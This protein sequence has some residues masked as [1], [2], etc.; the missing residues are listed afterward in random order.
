[1]E[2]NNGC[3]VCGC[4]EIGKGKLIGHAN[5]IP[6]DKFFSGGSEIVADICTK[7][8]QVLSLKVI[9]PEMFKLKK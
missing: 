2:N 3:P 4:T 6:V 9:K 5:M 1:M 8:G 7:C